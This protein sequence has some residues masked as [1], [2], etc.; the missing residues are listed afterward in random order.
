VRKCQCCKEYGH[1][2]TQCP[3]DPNIRSTKFFEIEDEDDR[4]ADQQRDKKKLNVDS[5]ILTLKMLAELS[6]AKNAKL[7]GKDLMCFDDF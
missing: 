7:K 3:K 5:S 6:R 4:I 1:L 2:E